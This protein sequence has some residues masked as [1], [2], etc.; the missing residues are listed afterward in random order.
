MRAV[1]DRAE[2]PE[3]VGP[4]VYVVHCVDTEGPLEESLE[5]TF[6][7]LRKERGIDLPPDRDTLS[8]LQNAAMDLSGEE[9]EIAEFLA[10]S[11]LAYL[12]SWEDVE[13]MV[14]AMTSESSRLS[15]ADPQGNPYAFTW[16]IIDV[17]GYVDN[18]RRK[19]LGWHVIWDK[20]QRLLRSS[21]GID[22]LGMAFPYG[23]SRRPCTR[24][25][26]VLDKQRLARAGSGQKD[27]RT[28]LVPVNVSGRWR[29]RK[30]GSKLLAGAIRAVR[31][32]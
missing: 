17:V 20:Y 6:E 9:K 2:R 14:Q 8:A 4:R 5:A 24:L 10:P 18:P 16:Y 32:F 19:A 31:L 13:R 7:R 1:N 22:S 29:N 15:Y 25:Q 3:D 26:H 11:R 30:D 28:R 21:L 23:S 27:H 12:S